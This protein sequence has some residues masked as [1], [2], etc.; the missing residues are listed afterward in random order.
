MI[1]INRRGKITKKRED[2]NMKILNTGVKWLS[3]I[4]IGMTITLG[5]IEIAHNRVVEIES[6]EVLEN[7]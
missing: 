2:N 4:L 3:I 7:E 5:F 1:G 6:N